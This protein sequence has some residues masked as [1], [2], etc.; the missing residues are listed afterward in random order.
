MINVAI[1]VN[2]KSGGGAERSMNILANE[3]FNRGYKVSLIA[4]NQSPP[5]FI[6]IKCQLFEIGRVWNDGLFL[7]FKSW[8]KYMNV[9]YKLKP[10]LLIVNCDL[11]EFFTVFLFKKFNI[12]CVEHSQNPWR[13]R[14]VLGKIVRYLLGI[15]KAKWV[16]VSGHLTIWP[17][18]LAPNKV[19]LNAVEGLGKSQLQFSGPI[20]RLVFIGRLTF[21]KNPHAFVRIASNL[22][23]PVLIIGEG[24]DKSKIFE[25]ANE[26]KLDADFVGFVKNPWSLMQKNDL[27]LVPSV[28][29]GD[30]LVVLEA[31]QRGVP[32]IISDIIEF[33]RF[34]LQKINYAKNEKEFIDIISLEILNNAV[35]CV[36]QSITR[37]I[38]LDRNIQ[39]ICDSW[40]NLIDNTINQNR[41]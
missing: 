21:Q 7:T 30:G 9:I 23:L 27:L 10:S 31:L 29:E 8:V 11:P 39:T 24:T 35:F 13:T 15:K 18:N 20:K 17:K 2:S 26:A 36:D 3:L 40:E 19:I 28:Y 41:I 33:R 5:D 32:L 4:I 37:K 1:V 16:A 34:E 25:M 14:V 22:N 6:R 12:I 38:L